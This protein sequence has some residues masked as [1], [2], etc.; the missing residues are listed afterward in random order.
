M[1]SWLEIKRTYFHLLYSFE[2]RKERIDGQI[3]N[4]KINLLQ[5]KV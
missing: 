4:S 5:P 2:R 1:K 3:K